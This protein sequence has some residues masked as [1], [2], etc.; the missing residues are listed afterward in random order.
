[1]ADA[2]HEV[3]ALD[4][5]LAMAAVAEIRSGQVVGLGTGRTARRGIAALAARASREGLDLTCVPTSESSAAYAQRLGLRL[6]EF[7]TTERVDYLFDGADEVDPEM[8]MLKGAGGAV[9]RERLVARASRRRVY[10]VEEHKLVDR[11]GERTPLAVAIMAFGMASIRAALRDLGLSGVLRRAMDGSLYLTDNGNLVL[12]VPLNNHHN[13]YEH[14]ASALSR[15]PGV[16][17]HGMFL[18]EA[19]DV[20]VQRA[21]GSIERLLRPPQDGD[22]DDGD[23]GQAYGTVR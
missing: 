3:D 1:M 11:L 2:P 19:T 13:D 18:V 8:R 6:G 14:L 9:T 21:D 4:D 22:E 15:T 20:L 5:A 10:M 23:D 12:D 16:I 7:A 17:D